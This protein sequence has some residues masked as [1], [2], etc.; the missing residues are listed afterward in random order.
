[1]FTPE[2]GDRPGVPNIGIVVTDGESNRDAELTIPE[3]TKA[4]DAGII[5]FAV[6]IGD[7]VG[8]RKWIRWELPVTYFQFS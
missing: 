2:A 7:E 6:A 5:L 1:M 8:Y 3:A 4:Q